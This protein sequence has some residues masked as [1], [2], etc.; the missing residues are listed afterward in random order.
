MAEITV[1]G[2]FN[3][4]QTRESAKG[5]YGTFSIAERQKERD[6][7]FSKVYYNAVYFKGD[8]PPDGSFGTAKGYLSQRKYKDKTGAE[9]VSLDINVQ[10]L[11][12]APPRDAAPTAPAEDPFGI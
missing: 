8:A 9:R 4:P 1:R 6:G 5:S 3:K 10:E 12:I 2:Y 11:D 7:S